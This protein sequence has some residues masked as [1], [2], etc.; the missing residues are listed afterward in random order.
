MK[1]KML[2]NLDEYKILN[3]YRDN[4]HPLPEALSKQIRQIDYLSAA[5]ISML[6]LPLAPVHSHPPEHNLIKMA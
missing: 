4:P 2:R 5:S 6:C 1:L 3:P